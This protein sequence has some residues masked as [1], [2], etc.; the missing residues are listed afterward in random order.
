MNASIG[1]PSAQAVFG[2]GQTSSGRSRAD[3]AMVAAK[4]RMQTMGRRT[5]RE[6][7]Q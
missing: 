4:A 1:L 6:M 7:L 3:A 2:V 5:E